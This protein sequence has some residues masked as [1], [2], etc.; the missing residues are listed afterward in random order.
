[1]VNN[2]QLRTVGE[3]ASTEPYSTQIGPFGEKIRAQNYT[4][5][6]APVLRGTNV[7]PEGRFH[8]DDFVFIDPALA[9]SEF[10]K[11]VCEADD[12]ILCHKGTLGKIGVIP[13]K[14]RFKKYIMG[15]SMMKVRCDR[16][17]LEPLYLYYWLCSRDG[18]QY[19]FSRVSQVGVPQIQR[20][21]TTLREATLPVPPLPEQKAIAAVLGT[22]DDKIELNR[23]MNTTLEATARALFQS[24]FVDFDPVR[25]KLDGRQPTGLD[26]ASAAVFPS[27][28]E[29]SELGPIPQRWEVKPLSELVDVVKGRSYRSEELAE[30]QTALVTLKS[31]LRG[32]GYRIDGLKPFTG[33]YKLNQRVRP[34]DL[35]VAFT[36]VTQAA[37]VIG[38]PALVR[39]DDR[40]ETLVASLDV[41]IVTPKS[42]HVSIPFL[43]CLFLAS[44][45]QSHTYAHT[46]G[47]T[48]L[49]LGA[50][51]IPSFICV[52]PP[53][54][55]AKLFAKRA[56]PMFRMIDENAKQSRTLATLRD[57]LLPKLLSGESSVPQ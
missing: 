21:L 50:G 42:K 5:T 40:F 32:G 7:N 47:T 14:S 44:E 43:Y 38:K 57:T 24:W 39:S 27:E 51:A 12:V 26:P 25:A 15:N 45:F 31:F 11:F 16:S 56:E 18:Q 55:L 30:S 35:V 20:P 19:L 48:V 37:D 6:G 4:L 34:G 13:K 36:D 10:N 3:C 53:V 2:W 23:R 49:H 22:L 54:D 46:T 1:M 17:K 52:V 8:D 33:E 29:D 9:E 28:F 41:G